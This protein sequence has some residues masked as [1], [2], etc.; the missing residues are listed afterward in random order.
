MKKI[1]IFLLFVFSFSGCE[2]DDICDP[3]TPTTPQLVIE[4]FDAAD[5]VKTRT[6]MFLKVYQEEV[7]D[8]LAFNP[9][10]FGELKYIT[11][12]SKI[13]LP[14]RVTA[15]KVKYKLIF[16]NKLKEPRV[17]DDIEFNY[18]RENVFVSR[19]CGFRTIFDLKGPDVFDPAI[20]NGKKDIFTGNWIKNITITKSKI[21][22]ENETH[23]KIFF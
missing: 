22:D 7:K 8:T 14:L 4:F 12:N 19:A 15:N 21:N 18:T 1:I 11:N 13:K 2:K 23:V 20:L 16:N 3:N 10:S 9:S 17:I 5:P 6:D